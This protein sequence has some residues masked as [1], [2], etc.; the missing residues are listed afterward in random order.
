MVH[1]LRTTINKWG[2]M[3]PKSFYK[4]K[5]MVNR[6]KHQLTD[7]EKVFTNP[8]CDRRLMSIIDTELKKL[9]S[10]SVKY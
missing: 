2:L 8:T 5:D 10:F 7:W 3:K 1:P 4:S 9:E 6:T